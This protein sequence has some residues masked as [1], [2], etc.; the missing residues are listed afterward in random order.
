MI[1]SPWVETKGDACKG[2][3]MVMMDA[4]R[5]L[6]DDFKSSSWAIWSEDYPDAGCAENRV[7][8]GLN[9]DAIYEMIAENIEQLNPSVILMGVNPSGTLPGPYSNFHSPDLQR[10]NDVYLKRAIQDGELPQLE[11]AYMTDLLK[12]EENAQAHSTPE[13][14]DSDITKLEDELTILGAESY[15]IICFGKSKFKPALSS[16]FEDSPREI[17]RVTPSIYKY[18]V[19]VGSYSVDFYAAYHYS[20]THQRDMRKQLEFLNEYIA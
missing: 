14:Q 6:K 18:D 7:W 4:I 19:E 2:Q 5:E 13:M 9:S 17:G 10:N 16:W 1:A 20:R 8:D 15:D 3:G 11:G 12:D